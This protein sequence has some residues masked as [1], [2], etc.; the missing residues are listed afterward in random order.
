MDVLVTGGTISL[1]YNLGKK[2]LI[3]SDSHIHK[4]IK[5]SNIALDI[6]L[7][8]ISLLDSGDLITNKDLMDKLKT[9]CIKSSAKHIIILTGTDK[10]TEIGT[11]IMNLNLDKTI[12][13]TGSMV[14]YSVHSTIE[15]A[16]FNF[17]CAVGFV[18]TLPSNTYIAMNGKYW[19]ADKCKKDYEKNIF[20]DK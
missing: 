10:M 1:E 12:I 17:G 4:I 5:N 20:V 18:Q 7:H 6:T 14:P 2:G 11:E 15:D 8:Y 13:L 19:V 3:F 16:V 9:E